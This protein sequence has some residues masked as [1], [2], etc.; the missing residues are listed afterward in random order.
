MAGTIKQ[1]HKYHRL[2]H[3]AIKGCLIILNR[4]KFLVVWIL[5]KFIL[6]T[7][8]ISQGILFKAL[9]VCFRAESLCNSN[10]QVSSVFFCSWWSDTPYNM[11]GARLLQHEAPEV[12]GEA[13]TQMRLYLHWVEDLFKHSTPLPRTTFIEHWATYSCICWTSWNYLSTF[14]LFYQESSY[15]TIVWILHWKKYEKKYS[16]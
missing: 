10:I 7:P 12:V 6:G 11:F 1:I 2:F 4:I 13:L 14:V 16:F 5:L 8:V 9:C 15:Y 3:Y